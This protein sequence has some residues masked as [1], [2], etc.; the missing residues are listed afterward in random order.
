MDKYDL[1][2]PPD[3]PE[4]F[5][6]LSHES[7]IHFRAYMANANKPINT[8]THDWMIDSGSTNHMFFD[9]EE[10]TNY[11]PHR[12]GIT[13]A[14]G[15]VVWT[16][17][18]GTVEM[19]WILEDGSSNMVNIADVLHVPDLTCG[20]FSISQ[21][22]RKGFGINF[23]G[24]DCHLYKEDYLVESAPKVN[25]TYIL[26]VSQSTARIARDI[27]GNMKALATSLM[28]NEEAVEL[29]H[30]RMG[31]LNEADLKRLVNMSKGIMLTQ[32]PRVR[33]ICDACSK[34]KSVR[35]V[36]RRIQHE[37]LEKL[38]KIHMDLGGPFNVS[39]D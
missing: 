27:Q 30:R 14:D 26:S 2:S 12:V 3:S 20:L 5:I 24:D 36:S 6:Q 23:L 7:S 33:P 8:T 10:F 39:L 37:I 29:W 11:Q 13:I 22:T 34:A 15:T 18:I 16:K 1:D 17:G 25:N 9:K 38:G 35:K 32:K 19:E 31:H 4:D 21:A 28:F